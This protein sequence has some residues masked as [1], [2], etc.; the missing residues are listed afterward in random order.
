M[1][2]VMLRPSTYPRSRRVDRKAATS[3]LASTA[4]IGESIPIKGRTED[5]C[6]RPAT[7]QAWVAAA[8]PKSA[9]KSRRFN[10]VNCICCPKQDSEAS[11]RNDEDQVRAR[12]SAGFRTG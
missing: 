10:R 7:G 6:A 3:D 5:N 2:I 11:Y 4:V 12:R 8:P 1:T 9:M